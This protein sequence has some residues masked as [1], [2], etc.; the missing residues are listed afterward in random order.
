MHTIE[1]HDAKV[2][3]VQHTQVSSNV[4]TLYVYTRTLLALSMSLSPST[5]VN[6]Q[7]LLSLQ[8]NLEVV[9]Q[10]RSL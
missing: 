5:E 7:S 10:I 1:K 2:V 8:K 4:Y 9:L 6:A 3:G